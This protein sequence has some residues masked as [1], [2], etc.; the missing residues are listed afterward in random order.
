MSRAT[1]EIKPESKKGLTGSGSTFLRGTFDFDVEMTVIDKSV[2]AKVMLH[3]HHEGPPG[4]AHG[5]SIAT[6]MDELKLEDVLFI[7]YLFWK[8][9][10]S[11]WALTIK[12]GY[13]AIISIM[14]GFKQDRKNQFI[15][16]GS[17][18]S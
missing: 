18:V 13:S 6:V 8:T 5:G 14:R 3:G 17:L 1:P 10:V 7:C 16:N 12:R 4:H 9:A 11:G 2:T 15:G